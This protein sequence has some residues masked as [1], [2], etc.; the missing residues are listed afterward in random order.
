M[1]LSPGPERPVS[2]ANKSGKYRA[3][4]WPERPVSAANKSGKYR[5]K[6]WPE[7]PVSD[8]EQEREATG[9]TTGSLTYSRVRYVDVRRYRVLSR[10]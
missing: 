10:C 5:A 8:G 9:A 2:A 6:P 3:K 1:R 4:P 7:R